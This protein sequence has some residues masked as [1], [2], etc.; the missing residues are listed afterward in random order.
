MTSLFYNDSRQRLPDPKKYN[1]TKKGDIYFQVFQIQ[2]TIYDGMG[3][4]HSLVGNSY[5][6]K[7]PQSNFLR[8]PA[9]SRRFWSSPPKAFCQICLVPCPYLT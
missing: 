5:V 3:N 1:G 9:L 7:I 4:V 2:R 6:F 8:K